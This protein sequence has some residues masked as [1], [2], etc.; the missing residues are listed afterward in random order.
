TFSGPLIPGEE[1]TITV[2]ATETTGLLNAWIDFSGDGS[3]TDSGE[4]IALNETITAGESITLVIPVPLTATQGIT[5]YARFRFSTDSD[6]TPTGLA[7]DGE[8]EDYA[9]NTLRLDYGDLP[10]GHLSPLT[11]YAMPLYPTQIVSDG[12]RHIILSMNNPT[13]GSTVDDESDGQPAREADGDDVYDGSDDEDGV[14]FSG[15]LV[16]GEEV[17]ITVSA[18]PT[19]TGLLNAWLDFDGDGSLTDSGE[20]I[21][22]NETITAG[23]SITLVIPVPLTA[24]QGITTY[25]RFR[26]S[27]DS[28]LTPTGLASDGEIEDYAIP[29]REMDY[30][31]APDADYT[32]VYTSDGARHVI[33][34]VDNPT[35]GS[36]VDAE[37]DGRPSAGAD[38][39]DTTDTPDDED[40]VSFDSPLV[41]GEVA[42]IT[43]S[44]AITGSDGVLNAWIDFGGNDDWGEAGDQIALNETITAGGSIV[45]TFTVPLTS[46]QGDDTYARFR[47]SS[48]PDLTPS[49]L[50]P[51][52]EVEDYVLNLSELE[53]GDL[54]DGP[55]P[56]RFASNG[57]RHNI[58]PVDN[59]TLGSLVDAEFDG[60]PSTEA[61][62]DDNTG[63]PDDEDGVTFLTPLM[64]DQAAQIQV[65]AGSDGYLNAWI[66][67][68]GD[69]LLDTITVTAID[70]TPV[71]STM[72]DI[73]MT[74]GV[75]TFTIQVPD[76]TISSSVYSRFRFTSYDTNGTL[77][78]TGRATDGEVE[79]Y[80]LMSLGNLV[81][82]DGG[83]GS[84]GVRNDGAQNGTEA[85]IAGVTVE[86][87]RYDQTPGTDAPITATVTDA[88][89][90]Y[91][92]TGL[93]PYTYVVHIPASQFGDGQP[94]EGLTSSTDWGLPDDDYDQDQ[95]ENG[96]DEAAPEL[97]GVSSLSVTLTLGNEPT[98]EDGDANS[99]LTVDFGFYGG[100]IG[101]YVWLELLRDGVQNGLFE[102]PISG[103]VVDLY[104]SSTGAHLGSDTTDASGLYLFD[105]LPLGVTY[106][107]QLS[108]VNFAPGGAL[109]P[110]TA[111]LLG[112]TALDNTDSN[113]NPDALFD[114]AGYAVT[115]T[116]TTAISEDLTLDFGFIELVSLGNYVWFDTDDSGAVDAN[117][118]GVPG[119][120]IELY[121]DSDES[122]D[123][124]PGA[125]QYVGAT[126]TDA[127][128]HYTFTDL[129][130]SLYPTQTYIVVITDTN[131][132]LATGGALAPYTA[133]LYLGGTPLDNTD[134]NATPD[135]L[136]G[137]AGYAVTTTLT[138]V[139]SEDL[140]L[141]F[142][143]IEL[144]SLGNYVWF[145]TDDSGAV[146]ADEVGVPG[147]EIELYQD[148]DE[149]G[150]FT[151]G[152]DQY[153]G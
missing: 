117:E 35:L 147:V 36:I 142:G 129:L 17:T 57:A 148:S 104:D 51:D 71:I 20:Q 89:G 150:D 136:F 31:D 113:A 108:Q 30:G 100:R 64:R 84:G 95:D 13:L 69:G 146:D 81:W 68:D 107:V 145:D 105:D 110:Y 78:Y 9:L 59:P 114:G 116:L 123:F 111:T 138:T 91:T 37:T 43:V 14:T 24:T 55:Y 125:D 97:N 32:T 49:G 121:Q 141:D 82:M 152:A 25:A 80:V 58:L 65:E 132:S 106:T 27:T 88:S 87:Y 75:H 92:F 38:G 127:T 8:I 40:G 112:G 119:V 143:F 128:G 149:S 137:G 124:T 102:T 77:S 96:V 44:A 54:P 48:E 73:S 122:G 15:P 103:V 61:D 99:N 109:A 74:T 67:F 41:P 60:Q 10:D 140:T 2:S 5:T 135:A 29:I 86:L 4:Q 33:L 98:S 18:A 50:A 76:V 21:A 28:D 22:L 70:G 42:T 26:F 19:A 56:T 11:G 1:I 23:E 62:G 12:G 139:I 16:P 52:G 151:P 63:T 72:N 39:D 90:Y 79:D 93:T 94:L 133:T 53:Y 34:P 83:A 126:T 66:D 130:P 120:E 101:D 131:F 118:V 45:I 3:L 7:S 6:L 144:V 46:V 134:S 153:V 47:F 85:G 115:T